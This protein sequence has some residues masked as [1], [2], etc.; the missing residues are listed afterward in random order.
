ML[1][2]I[3]CVTF[4]VLVVLRPF[5]SHFDNMQS[6]TM[7][8]WSGAIILMAI[9]RSDDMAAS[10]VFAQTLWSLLALVV[11]LLMAAVRWMGGLLERDDEEEERPAN[12]LETLVTVGETTASVMT[13]PVVPAP[14]WEMDDV[15]R[16]GLE[17]AEPVDQ[18]PLDGDSVD[19]LTRNMSVLR[20]KP[21]SSASSAR[22]IV[23]KWM[24]SP[25]DDHAPTVF[26]RCQPSGRLLDQQLLSVSRAL[27]SK[28][29]ISAL[30]ATARI[31]EVYPVASFEDRLFYLGRLIQVICSTS[32]TQ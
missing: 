17:A 13:A 21:G 27:P 8:A 32:V 3:T 15:L 2:G 28:E 6:C 30:V 4:L 18:L 16:C 24:E 7:N 23:P 31:G 1:F 9:W 14:E 25:L 10:F 29:A 22:W 20:R 26:L 11:P 5:A 19:W 12:D